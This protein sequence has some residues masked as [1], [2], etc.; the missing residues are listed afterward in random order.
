VR[1][2]VGLERRALLAR[3]QVD[4]QRRSA[5][6]WPPHVHEVPLESA[7]LH[8][9]DRAAREQQVA[10]EPRVP[11]PAAVRLRRRLQEAVRR[12]ELRGFTFSTGVS[13]WAPTILNAPPGLY[14][15]PT[16]NA[17]IVLL[18]RV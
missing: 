6:D 12:L 9:H 11:Q 5:Q 18:L 8:F 16:A 4:A 15:S 13:V 17:T 2:L 14:A 7:A 3:L 1:L 10:V